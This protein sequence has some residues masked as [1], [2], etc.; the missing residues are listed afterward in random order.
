MTPAAILFRTAVGTLHRAAARNALADRSA[1][2]QRAVARA[3]EQAR[4]LDSMAIAASVEE[5][6]AASIAEQAV[7]L[8]H[9]S[10]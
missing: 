3:R 4:H 2:A 5:A 8:N 9:P 6:I 1:D 7:A 10:P